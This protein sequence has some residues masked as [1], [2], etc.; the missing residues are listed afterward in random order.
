MKTNTRTRTLLSLATAAALV[1][2][3]C[4]NDS[5]GG[6]SAPRVGG[7]A[8]GMSGTGL[9]LQ[10]NRANSKSITVNGEFTF[11]AME[12]GGAC[13]VTVKTHPTGP[14]QNCDVSYGSGTLAAVN[15]TDLAVTGSPWTKQ[16]GMAGVSTN[17]L[18]FPV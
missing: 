7:T 6:S 1:L 16:M 5:G 2:S 12:D 8:S 11:D 14:D 9:V 18:H 4:S 3:G 10:S 13:A 17:A 15:A